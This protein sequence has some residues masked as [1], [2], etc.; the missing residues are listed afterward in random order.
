MKTVVIIQARVGSTRLPRKVL[1]R[2][3]NETVL[4]R[5][6]ARMRHCERVD[7]VVVA[8]TTGDADDAI[9]DECRRCKVRVIRG[10]E[11]DVLARYH[12]AALVSRA[13]EIIRI[14][15]DCPLIDPLL[16]D[17]L[18]LRY[19]ERQNSGCPVDYISNTQPRTYPHGLDMEMFSMRALQIAHEA[20]TKKYER[21]HV[22]PF[23][24]QHPDR[25]VIDNITQSIDQSSMR[26]TLDEPT[27]FVFF[28]AV[29][30]NFRRDEFITTDQVL[31]LLARQPELSRINA[32][33]KQKALKAA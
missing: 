21:E 32:T 1:L 11:H 6:V 7:E 31:G 19:Q 12:Q 8:T 18:V 27:D 29:F 17:E 14:T 5:I 30:R 25:F 16:V 23:F 4:S 13:T 2:L 26:W 33:V 28:Q 9:V 24:Y 10:S 3:G 15:A 22:T 20:A